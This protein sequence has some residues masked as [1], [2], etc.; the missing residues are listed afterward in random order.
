MTIGGPPRHF[1]K[2]ATLYSVPSQVGNT[3][4]VTGANSGTGMEASRKLAGAGAHVIMAVRSLEKGERARKEILTTY[5]DAN[6]DVQHLDLADLSSVNEFTDTFKAHHQ[7]L[8]LLVNNAGVMAPPK[9]LLSAEGFELQFAT[10]FLGPF[11]LTLRLLALLLA[12]PSSRV[13]TM[14]SSVAAIG[15]IRFHDLQHTR[16]YIPYL[17]YAQSKLADLLFSQELA[18]VA[19]QRNWDLVSNAAHP[20]YTQTNLLIAGSS[21]GKEHPRPSW[22]TKIMFLPSQGVERGTEPLLVASTSSLALS[23]SYYGPSRLFGTVGPSTLVR[24][25]RS[26]R[27][28]DKAR[29]LWDV[30]EELTGVTLSDAV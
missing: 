5:P 17:A 4:V 19:S 18:I 10:N 7:Q 6:I 23:G 25:P 2:G 11:A 8:N 14:S 28:P 16:R 15:T 12:T 9:R 22:L 26:A 30:A 21:L 24:P 20:G 3:I 29:R 27:N 13:T 1:A